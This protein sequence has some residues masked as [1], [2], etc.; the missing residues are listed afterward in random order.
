MPTFLSKKCEKLLHCKNF[1]HF[2][3]QK[4]SLHCIVGYKFVKHL[5]VGLLTSSLSYRFFEQLG[6]GL[7]ISELD[8]N[9]FFYFRK[10]FVG[11]LGWDTTQSKL[12]H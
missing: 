7:Q 6:P 1:S 11:G 10:I 2:V 4:I 8:N 12:D 3:Q 5:T 9:S